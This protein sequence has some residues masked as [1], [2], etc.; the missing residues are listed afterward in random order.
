MRRSADV[1]PADAAVGVGRRTDVA[2]PG[3]AF[4][5]GSAAVSTD[6]RALSTDSRVVST[7]SGT[8]RAR[9]RGAFAATAA[10]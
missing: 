2:R 1:A 3:V 9:T 10:E 6:S 8:F 5:T 4:V 7:D